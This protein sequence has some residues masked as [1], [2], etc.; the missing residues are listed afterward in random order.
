[1]ND[2]TTLARGWLAEHPSPE[3]ITDD[4][5]GWA[6]Q[7]GEAI[8]QR[9]HDLVDQLAPPIPDEPFMTRVGRLN[10]A[11]LTATEMAIDEHLPCYDPPQDETE[12]WTPLVPDYS[13]LL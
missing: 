6:E 4:P 13:D 7:T 8:R 11:R 12:G 3:T 9:I 2:F 5:T 10:A 1:M